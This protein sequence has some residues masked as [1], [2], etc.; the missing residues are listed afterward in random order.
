LA[1]E[2]FGGLPVEGTGHGA[3]DRSPS[4][5]PLAASSHMITTA[6]SITRTGASLVTVRNQTCD[7]LG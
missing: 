1:T 4:K 7:P 3:S 6:P 2:W 5:H